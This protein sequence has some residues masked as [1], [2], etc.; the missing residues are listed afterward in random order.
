MELNFARPPQSNDANDL[1]GECQHLLQPIIREVVRTA[2]AA[3]WSERDVLLAMA[4]VAWDLYEGR[5]SDSG[6]H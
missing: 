2:V 5:R 3:G 1:A 4:D 6:N